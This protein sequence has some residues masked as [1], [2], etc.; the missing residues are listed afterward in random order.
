M[1]FVGSLQRRLEA[2][3]QLS[4]GA[5]RTVTTIEITRGGTPLQSWNETRLFSP[6]SQYLSVSASYQT[7]LGQTNSQELA[8]MI[9]GG[10]FLAKDPLSPAWFARP[11][12][13][14]DASWL[15]EQGLGLGQ[16]VMDATPG[17]TASETPRHWKNGGRR[18]ACE[19]EIVSQTSW[20]ERLSGRVT[21]IDASMTMDTLRT[22][23]AS[24]RLTDGSIM[25]VVVTEE[26]VDWTPEIQEANGLERI[27]TTPPDAVDVTL[28]SWEKRDLVTRDKIK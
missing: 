9:D 17:W 15:N 14:V 3:C 5:R 20:L 8:W 11:V 28:N 12:A 21:L 7:E 2:N 19:S 10:E 27:Y 4:A 22:T 1:R 6:E 23:S 24:W 16:T 26:T 25:R 18:M 13:S